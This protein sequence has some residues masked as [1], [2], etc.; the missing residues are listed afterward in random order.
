M[1]GNR[2]RDVVQVKEDV[3]G[4]PVPDEAGVGA[5]PVVGDGL[6]GVLEV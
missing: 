1:V 2:V 6:D 3:E 4:C 5:V